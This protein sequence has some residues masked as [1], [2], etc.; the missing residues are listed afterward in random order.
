[1]NKVVTI[2]EK[3]AEIPPNCPFFRGAT[4]ID[5]EGYGTPLDWENAKGEHLIFP[6]RI[7]LTIASISRHYWQ[8]EVERLKRDGVIKVEE[9]F[10]MLKKD[11]EWRDIAR[12]AQE[13]LLTEGVNDA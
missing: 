6:S 13:K 12:I 8:E 3:Q 9:Y 7:V 1:M 5:S 11:L 2:Y 4:F 10:D